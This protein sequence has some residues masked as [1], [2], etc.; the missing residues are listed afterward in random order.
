MNMK[1]IA[2]L[3]GVSISTVS[4]ILNNK[5]DSISKETRER[6][7]DIARKYNYARYTPSI[8]SSSKTWLIGVIIKSHMTTGITISGMIESA[9]TAGYHTIVCET[10]GDINEELKNITAL[11]RYKVDGILWE[12]VGEES[13]DHEKLLAEH[14]IPYLLFHDPKSKENIVDFKKLGYHATNILVQKRH[15]NIACLVTKGKRTDAFL[16]GYQDCLFE[17]NI[18]V[19]KKLIYDTVDDTL[20]KRIN[21]HSIS[22][23]VSSH[24]SGALSFFE[25][26]TSL[27]YQIPYD[28]SLVSL[29]DDS[30]KL[31]TFPHIST[32]TIPNKKFGAFLCKKLISIIEKEADFHEI[33][34]PEITL[35]NTSTIDIPFNL[36]PKHLIVIGSLN[37]DTYLNVNTIPEAGKTISTSTSSI[38]P[39]G[40]AINQAVG[41]AKLGHTVSVIGNVGSDLD[42]NLI[43]DAIKQH[44]INPVGIKRCNNT[45]TGKAY[46][47]LQPD[48]QSLTSILSGANSTLSPEDIDS[49]KLLF[50]NTG[51]CL[52]QTEIPSQTVLKALRTAH[53]NGASTI[54]K[55]SACTHLSQEILKE[56]DILVASADELS[57]LCPAENDTFISRIHFLTNNQIDHI[58]I[59]LGNRNYYIK[60]PDWEET[61][62]LPPMPTIDTT[63]MCDAFISALASYL[64]YGYSFQSSVR[65]ALYAASFSAT[66]EGVLPALVSKTSLESYIRQT[67]PELLVKK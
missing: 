60:S 22:G 14:N 20:I 57:D 50:E 45:H 8:T 41:V 7:L 30:R 52:V 25:K 4:K 23:I 9:Q 66:R 46:I 19:S 11:C 27:H 43:Y 58:I 37:V 40:K 42:S 1:K 13:R 2:E 53:I 59:A 16:K 38:Y 49:K 6:V 54:L 39:G 64:M 35:D 26:I 17:H 47:F 63:G 12:P 10:N 44:K 48:G 29:K 56:T 32:L 51:Y 3:S 55:P 15:T 5:D 21:N 36:K 34:S 67:E 18:S 24:F 62:C 31:V 65:I 28:V 61:L 33:F